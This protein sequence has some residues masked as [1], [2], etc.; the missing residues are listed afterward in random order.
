MLK[1][2]FR[3]SLLL[4]K[5]MLLFGCMKPT[6]QK[7]TD[8]TTE[9]SERHALTRQRSEQEFGELEGSLSNKTSS[10]AVS[11]ESKQSELKKII[12][13]YLPAMIHLSQ[14]LIGLLQDLPIQI[15]TLA[16]DRQRKTGL[17]TPK[18]RKVRH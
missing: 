4:I 12:K 9:K 8:D 10:S 1:V 13:V 17:I 3:I 2:L 11:K 6:V 16:L 18:K 7:P 14:N 15:T 5:T